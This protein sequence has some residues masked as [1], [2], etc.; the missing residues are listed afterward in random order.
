MACF[1]A[2]SAEEINS[3]INRT[4]RAG[5]SI[6]P[7]TDCK[8]SYNHSINQLERTSSPTCLKSL[9]V[10]SMKR[11]CPDEKG[12]YYPA[13][14]LL[15]WK[16]GGLWRCYSIGHGRT[17]SWCHCYRYFCNSACQTQ[18]RHWIVVPAEIGSGWKYYNAFSAS[19]DFVSLSEP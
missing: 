4:V 2:V 6:R 14:P 5:V 7:I 11:L 19:F 15:S 18:Y 1:C 10:T 12:Q 17:V 13:L 8:L 16:L 3:P 9:P